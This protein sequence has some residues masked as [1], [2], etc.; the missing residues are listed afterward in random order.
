MRMPS[1]HIHTI[2]EILDPNDVSWIQFIS[3]VDL[4]YYH[5]RY[6]DYGCNLY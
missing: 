5:T 4:F 1:Y 3:W 6:F 2:G